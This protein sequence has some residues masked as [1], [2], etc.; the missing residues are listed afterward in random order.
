MEHVY[1]CDSTSR[2]YIT[3]F[4]SGHNYEILDLAISPDATT[5][6]SVGTDSQAVVWDVSG[7]KVRC[8]LQ[9]HTGRINSVAMLSPVVCVTGSV[10]CTARVW[11]LRAKS[12]RGNCV[13]TMGDAA[14]SVSAVAAGEKSILCGSM[15]GCV[16]TYD[17]RAGVRRADHV[18]AP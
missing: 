14:D 12:G 5:L 6:I 4:T 17:V 8:R 18:G 15:D 11:D 13:Q 10:D 1:V 2:S 3:S 7:T 16:Y 9:G